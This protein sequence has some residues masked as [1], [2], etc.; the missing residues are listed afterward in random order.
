M[1]AL[2]HLVAAVAL[3]SWATTTFAAADDDGPMLADAGGLSL[4][5]YG[6]QAINAAHGGAASHVELAGLRIDDREQADGI[7]I[8]RDGG[9]TRIALETLLETL[10]FTARRD[11]P[12]A[13]VDTPLGTA[14]IGLGDCLRQ[15]GGH[16]CAIDRVAAAMALDI[17][18]D[19]AEFSVRVRTAWPRDAAT[20]PAGDG[21]PADIAAPRASF[22]YAR[23]SVDY[24]HGNG[25]DG[26]LGSGEF[27]GGLGDGY[28]RSAWFDDGTGRRGLYDY[29]WITQHGNT[30]ALVG[31]QVM[32]LDPLLPSFDL[33]GAQGVWTNAPQ[34]IFADT[35]G[36]RRL[37]SERVMPERALHGEGPP[38]GRAELRIGGVLVDSTVIPLSGRYTLDAPGPRNDPLAVVQV[39]LYERAFDSV[40]V[41]VEDRSFQTG[42]RLLAD[43]AV[44]Q[45]AG[46][47][48]Q[49][50]PLGDSTLRNRLDDRGA[51][52]WQVRYGVG[53]ALTLEAAVQQSE[54][55]RYAIGGAHVGLGGFGTLSALV[56]RN[57]N[58]DGALR[59]Q[60]EG[61]RRQWFWRGYLQDEDA[62]YRYPDADLAGERSLRY[63]ETGWIGRRWMLSVIGREEQDLATGRTI[64]YIKPAL[65]VQPIDTL[66]LS[67]RPDSDGDYG[68]LARWTP[69][70]RLYL[71]AYRDADRDQLEAQWTLPRDTR[72]VAGWV[73]EEA[74]GQRHSL[75]GY[76]D[77]AGARNWHYGAGVLEADH[78]FGWLLEAGTELGSGS[79]LSAQAL[80]DPLV[81]NSGGGGMTMWVNLTIDLVNTGSGFTRA[82]WRADY[83]VRGAVAG[84]L[85]LPPT[86]A[87]ETLGGI[88]VRVD[89]NVRATT[90]AH[91]RFH[92]GDLEPGV[93]QVELDDENL[94]LDFTPA[95]RS[96]RVEVAAGRA[97]SV[98]FAL[99][100]R[101]GLARRALGPDGKARAGIVVRLLD[102]D[103]R[104]LAR[105]ASD[106]WGF[107]RFSELLPG[108]YRLLAD[109]TS[110]AATRTVDLVDQHVFDQ[111]LV[112]SP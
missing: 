61:Q 28:W 107:Y 55:G 73:N 23:T 83:S 30:R 111:D 84:R 63:A 35:L 102:A 65:S 42:D 5:T 70:P 94:P 57:D 14:R 108:R 47:G 58:G 64:D 13:R 66:S 17:A 26:F 20:I 112:V 86:R 43:G 18:F 78:A 106:A 98:R 99:E 29:A 101:V 59:V 110:A 105:Q 33:L 77:R 93:H 41:R 82:A 90:D 109:G 2:V 39:L 74:F 97:T 21:L 52:F 11:G 91:G 71:N 44:V 22:S 32:G 85:V 81:R 69:T 72:V 67:V 76:R 10:G 54:E 48:V 60:T 104:E 88:P 19:A 15:A 45:F 96:T 51:G 1:N 4:P 50:N 8:V 53:S 31:H 100:A 92:V 79:T 7:G 9:R 27:G 24:R 80:D 103:G 87:G 16:F 25:S 75:V 68:W 89:G 56:G 12:D 95:R 34:S 38:G 40:P 62:R 36:S 37:V 3:V 6:L 46:L 49:G